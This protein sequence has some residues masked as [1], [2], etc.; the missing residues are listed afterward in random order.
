MLLLIPEMCLVGNC[1]TCSATD[2]KLRSNPFNGKQQCMNCRVTHPK[3]AII[4]ITDIKSQYKLK[5]NDLR[6]L[7]MVT[8]PKP[9]FLGGADRKWYLLKQVKARKEKILRDKEAEKER[10][11]RDRQEWVEKGKKFRQEEK[12]RA[13]EEKKAKK[14][15]MKREKVTEENKD[16]ETRGKAAKRKMEVEPE[17][18][19]E[20]EMPRK[21]KR[22]SFEA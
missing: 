13:K 4:G 2:E 8:E 19:V 6:G 16:F 11:K 22:F 21:K 5:D 18:D 10:V 14:D 15:A 12:E 7:R 20:D 1:E 17:T 9:A 3:Y